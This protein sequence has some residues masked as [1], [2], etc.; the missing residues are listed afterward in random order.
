M[1]V[2]TL[3]Q[4]DDPGDAGALY[5]ACLDTAAIDS[6][7]AAPLRPYLRAVTGLQGKDALVEA[8]APCPSLARFPCGS[9]LEPFPPSPL[10]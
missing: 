3:N 1:V 4:P 9:P 8:V 7:G 10:R 2:L 5:R 6:A